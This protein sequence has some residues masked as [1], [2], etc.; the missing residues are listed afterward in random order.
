MIRVTGTWS[1]VVAADR[2]G[3]GDRIGGDLTDFGPAR[4]VA[5]PALDHRAGGCGVDVAGQHQHRVVGR[6]VAVNQLLH[7]GHARPR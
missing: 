4:D 7:V 1:F 6:V 5:E 2:G 3:E